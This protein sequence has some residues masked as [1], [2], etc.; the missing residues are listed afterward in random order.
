MNWEKRRSRIIRV[1]IAGAATSMLITGVA[2]GAAG[3]FAQP[4]TSPESSGKNSTN[5]VSSD[6]NGD[7]DL[8]LAVANS[9]SNNVSV[10]LGNGAG[11]FV[12]AAGSPEATPPGASD[13]VAANLDADGDVDL[14]VAGTDVSILLNNG[15][16]DFAPALTEDTTTPVNSIAAAHMNP[17]TPDT[18]HIDLVVGQF[19]P[20]KVTVLINNG[21]GDGNFTALADV[22]VGNTADNTFDVAAGPIDNDTD[23]DVAVAHEFSGS[24]RTLSNTNGLGALATVGTP[25][26]LGTAGNAIDLEL[27]QYGSNAFNDLAV[28]NRQNNQVAILIG[29]G[30]G[31]WTAAG[32]SPE[33]LPAGGGPNAVAAGDFTNDGNLDLAVSAGFTGPAS[34]LFVLTGNGAGDFTVG[35]QINVGQ[36]IPLGIAPGDFLEDGDLDFAVANFFPEPSSAL[37]IMLNDYIPP[38]GGG[39]TPGVDPA[40]GPTGQR[41]AAL[42]KC[43]KIKSKK[44]KKNCKKKA[45]QL[46][47]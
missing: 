5:I 46:P 26:D 45:R 37:N 3:D 2:S 47:V 19:F 1:A 8:D 22:D 18:T 24:I 21:A 10:L 9:G 4:P 23:A 7:G 16:G 29:Q 17:A 12:A 13:L 11:D 20:A 36:N 42:K 27:G 34:R 31:N 44:K 39:S 30:D 14:A 15:A 40:V 33:A 35:P 38:G 43:A 6:F 41:A 28:A 25:V 32:T